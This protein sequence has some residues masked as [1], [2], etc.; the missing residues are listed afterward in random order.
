[1]INLNQPEPEIRECSCGKTAALKGTLLHWPFTTAGE[2]V[3]TLDGKKMSSYSFWVYE[4][5]WCRGAWT[6]RK[7][8]EKLLEER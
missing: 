8:R 7:N 6:R 4:C 3:M 5:K 1:M 2:Q